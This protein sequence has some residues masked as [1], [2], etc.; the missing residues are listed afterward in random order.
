MVRKEIVVELSVFF[1]IFAS[2]SAEFPLDAGRFGVA[3]DGKTDITASLQQAL[4]ACKDQGGGGVQ[5]A[6]GTFIVRGHLLIPD[7]VTL[8]G[9]FTAPTAWTEGKGTSLYA[10]EGHGSEEGTP[11]ITLG[12]NAVLKG[13][14]IYYPEQ[15]GDTVVPYPWCIAGGGGD[16]VTVQDCL[17]VNPYQAI[18]LGTR[19]SGRHFISR[20][21]G[22]PLRKG[23]FVDQCYVVGRIEN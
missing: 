8:A 12:A 6:Q 16:N 17:L 23:I 15:T 7:N 10:Y 13:L 1:L 20:V 19:P 14:T 18:D 5:L 22:C 3:G 11:F 9:V 21:Y 2:A 4:N